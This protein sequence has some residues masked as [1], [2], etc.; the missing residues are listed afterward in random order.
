MLR[1]I[2]HIFVVL[3]L[4]AIVTP[5]DV[6]A[7][8]YTMKGGVSYG[9]VATKEVA[10]G[11]D[12]MLNYYWEMNYGYRFATYRF[13]TVGLG[14]LGAGCTYNDIYLPLVLDVPYT[15]KTRFNNLIIPVKFKVTT[16]HRT[17]PR[18]Y[19]YVGVAP[20]WMFNEAREVKLNGELPDKKHDEFLFKWT[21][22]KTQA[23]LLGGGGIYYKHV[24]LDLSAYVS[25]FK[26]YN[27]FEAPMS[28]NSGVI[29][30]IG[31]QVSRDTK[32][33]W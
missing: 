7:Q 30:C 28:F 22:R 31:Y 24:V 6:Y 27:E 8:Q 9:R 25:I 11:T 3:M 13:I 32:K 26:D 2:G 15:V 12:K 10:N 16:E 14:Y 29:L 19:A 5:K 20:A 1:N 23:Y 18:G 21:P 17:R 33:R 4:A